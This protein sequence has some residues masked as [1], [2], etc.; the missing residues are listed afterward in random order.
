[1]VSVGVCRTPDPLGRT[2][3]RAISQGRSTIVIAVA[4]SAKKLL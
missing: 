4:K 3:R 2:L 1:M